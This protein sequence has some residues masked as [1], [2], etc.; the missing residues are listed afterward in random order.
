MRDKFGITP[1]TYAAGLGH[2]DSAKALLS[3][4]VDPLLEKSEKSLLSAE[5]DPLIEDSDTDFVSVAICARQYEL[6]SGIMQHLKTTEEGRNITQ[7]YG[8]RIL[9]QMATNRVGFDIPEPHLEVLVSAIGDINFKFDVGG[10]PHQ[11]SGNHLLHYEWRV[12]QIE[13]FMKH[14]FKDLNHKNSIGETA[15][16]CAVQDRFPGA[17]QYYIAMGANVDDQDIHG[18]CILAHSIYGNMRSQSFDYWYRC[19]QGTARALLNAGAD[20]EI[21]DDCDCHCSASGCTITHG[22]PA[23][24]ER[25]PHKVFYDSFQSTME[26]LYLL[27]DCGR[28]DVMRSALNSL[29]RIAHFG[30]LGM[31]HTCCGLSGVVHEGR[32]RRPENERVAIQTRERDK[33]KELETEMESIGDQLS[34]AELLARWQTLIF[35]S[36]L[37]YRD[38]KGLPPWKDGL[39]MWYVSTNEGC[40]GEEELVSLF[41]RSLRHLVEL[42]IVYEERGS[43]RRASTDW[44]AWYNRRLSWVL[45]LLDIFEVSPLYLRVGMQS[46]LEKECRHWEEGV[47]RGRKPNYRRGE[48]RAAAMMKHFWEARAEVLASKA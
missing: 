14:G 31:T 2:L 6:L 10:F 27:E 3:A 39:E 24:F 26:W 33:S 25:A 48:K 45:Q 1:L 40:F 29:I 28:E 23:S 12:E 9:T 38:R 7:A 22:F 30:A 15:L 37:S 42:E 8:R 41:T 44:D 32:S 13:V 16:M 43:A 17:A 46:C 11:I 36:H 18:T 5:E 47:R 34:L 4:G 20:T 21:N 35:Q 19:V